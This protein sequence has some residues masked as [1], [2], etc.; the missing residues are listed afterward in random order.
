MKRLL[1]GISKR[2]QAMPFIYWVLID[3]M[4]IQRRPKLERYHYFVK[5]L[6]PAIA[7]DASDTVRRLQLS[8]S[9][10][11]QVLIN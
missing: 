4:K 8:N 6:L 11:K 7:F 3:P 9:S 10:T 5:I 1:L 2:R